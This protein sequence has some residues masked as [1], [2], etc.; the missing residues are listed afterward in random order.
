MPTG[1]ENRNR[2]WLFEKCLFL[3]GENMEDV[4]PSEG[5]KDTDHSSIEDNILNQ[6]KEEAPFQSPPSPSSEEPPPN[7]EAEKSAI[8]AS[9]E[10]VA[11]IPV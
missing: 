3:Y 6:A 10:F 11:S 4:R 5:S 9:K 7:P 8:D 2:T 1:R